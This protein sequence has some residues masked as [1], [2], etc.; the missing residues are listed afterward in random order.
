MF[1]YTARARRRGEVSPDTAKGVANVRVQKAKEGPEGARALKPADMERALKPVDIERRALKP[2][3]YIYSRC[4]I[5]GKKGFEAGRHGKK[6]FE[7]G[8]AWYV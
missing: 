1:G 5:H 3:G 6:G 7:A 8:R 4:M 2:A